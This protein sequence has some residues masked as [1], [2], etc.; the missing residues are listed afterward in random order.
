M[1]LSSIAAGAVIFAA[2]Y[3]LVDIGFGAGA[4]ITKFCKEKLTKK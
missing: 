4:Q 2:G 3:Q 1:S